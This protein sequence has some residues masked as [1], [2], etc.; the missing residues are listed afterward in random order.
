MVCTESISLTSS[1]LKRRRNKLVR[2]QKI[3]VS[4]THVKLLVNRI[5]ASINGC[6]LTAKKKKQFILHFTTQCSITLHL[7]LTLASS[8][9]RCDSDF[10]CKEEGSPHSSNYCLIHLGPHLALALA[11][12][13]NS[14]SRSDAQAALC[15]QIAHSLPP[16]LAQV[17]WTVTEEDRLQDTGD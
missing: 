1:I 12:S 14:S 7:S 16:Y 17:P 2:T 15:G 11:V 4:F 9:R 10:C 13:G 3:N 5:Q 8:V 6:C